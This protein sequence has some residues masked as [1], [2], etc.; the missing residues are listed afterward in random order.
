ME[1]RTTSNQRV[2]ATGMIVAWYVGA[3]DSEP[4]P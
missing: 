1:L 4:H 3:V 2:E